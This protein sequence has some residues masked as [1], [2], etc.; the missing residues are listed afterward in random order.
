VTDPGTG[1]RTAR[2]VIRY[3]PGQEAKAQLLARYLAAGADIQQQPGLGGVDV[4][5]VVG[6]DFAGVLATPRPATAAAA[7]PSATPTPPPPAAPQC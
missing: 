1:T 4:V 3:G 7:A 5:L 6:R 2:T